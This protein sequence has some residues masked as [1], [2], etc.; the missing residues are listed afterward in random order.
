MSEQTIEK[1]R[2]AESGRYVAEQS[3]NQAFS[4]LDAAA[5]DR[6][7]DAVNNNDTPPPA[8]D[9]FRPMPE[10]PE[11]EQKT[12]GSDADGLRHAAREWQQH[13]AAAAEPTPRHYVDMRDGVTPRPRNETI[14]IDRAS[15][16]L[17]ARRAEELAAAEHTANEQLA[18]EVDQFRKD[19]L[20]RE[21]GKPTSEQ[22]PTEQLAPQ[23]ETQPEAPQQT[24]VQQA[25][26]DPE[27][28]QAIEQQVAVAE[29]TRQ[30]YMQAAQMLVHATEAQLI[31]NFPELRGVSA[32]NLPAVLHGINSRDPQR[33]Q[34]IVQSLQAAHQNIQVARQHQNAELQRHF[35]QSVQQFNSYAKA[36]QPH[37]FD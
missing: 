12:F 35:Q 36:A 24:K 15:R 11:P 16:D 1:P 32:Q 20:A 37:P 19:E 9:D 13:R 28:R 21:Q 5:Q 10:N 34:H 14:D 33:A 31:Q 7:T 6:V 23:P 2:D 3:V 18:K 22:A 27:I 26:A 25:L 17:G 30:Q 29:Q 8:L 4:N